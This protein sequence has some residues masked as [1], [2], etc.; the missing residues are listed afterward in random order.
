MDQSRITKEGIRIHAAEDFAGM[1]KAG[2]LAAQILDEVGD[3]VA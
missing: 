1:R 2:A 3:L